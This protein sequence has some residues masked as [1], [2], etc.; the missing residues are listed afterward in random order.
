LALQACGRKHETSQGLAA[1]RGADLTKERR[2]ARRV[3]VG[4]H[5]QEE[6]P[7]KAGKPTQAALWRLLRLACVESA[8]IHKAL[9]DKFLLVVSFGGMSALRYADRRL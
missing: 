4:E 9:W 6:P 5:R 1:T 3:G 7:E 2:P 8:D